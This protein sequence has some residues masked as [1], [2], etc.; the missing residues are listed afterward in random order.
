MTKTPCVKVETEESQMEQM[1][2]KRYPRGEN[3]TF[4]G[5]NDTFFEEVD[6]PEEREEGVV[7]CDKQN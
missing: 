6:D 5:E 4:L 3:D 7:C 2:Q 1:T